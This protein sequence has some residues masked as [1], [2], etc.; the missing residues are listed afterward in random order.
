MQCNVTTK[1]TF[2][3]A[4]TSPSPCHHTPESVNIS[5]QVT[6]LQEWG[7]SL[8]I[9][10]KHESTQC[11]AAAEAAAATTRRWA[12]AGRAVV[13]S[14]GSS[15][16]DLELFGES[17]LQLIHRVDDLDAERAAGH[18]LTRPQHVYVVDTDLGRVVAALDAAIIA[19]QPRHLHTERTCSGQRHTT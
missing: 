12:G 1:S 10:S 8:V 5:P 11:A 16:C 13:N 4:A 15:D 18:V 7:L 9:V 3:Y 17:T 2:H 19:R 14:A 6:T